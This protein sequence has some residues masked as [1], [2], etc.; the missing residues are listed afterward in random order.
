MSIDAQFLPVA[1]R[2][3]RRDL[4][5]VKDRIDG[6][7][8]RNIR[9]FEMLERDQECNL[10]KRWRERGDQSAAHQLVASHL[11]LV[12]KIADGDLRREMFLIG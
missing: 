12:A 11:R 9:R 1:L 7:Y 10:A 5:F 2:P 4:A 3:A 6:G 8:L